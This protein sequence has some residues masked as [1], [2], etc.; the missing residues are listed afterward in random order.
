MPVRPL[1]HLLPALGLVAGLA[2]AE[3]PPSSPRATPEEAPRAPAAAPGAD[4]SVAA[5]PA[6]AALHARAQALAATPYWHLLLRYERADGGVRSEARSP[7]FFLAP[8]GARDPAAE[9]H[10]LLDALH[11]PAGSDD[12]AAACRF[13]ARSAWLCKLPR[14]L[15]ASL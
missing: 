15:D 6:R 5:A 11:T 3:T 10:A 4:A 1:R 13:P 12:Q 8:D 7:A 9:I 14:Q 2:L